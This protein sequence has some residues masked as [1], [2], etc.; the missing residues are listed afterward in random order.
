MPESFTVISVSYFCRM[1]I[2]PQSSLLSEEFSK[3]KELI[4]AHCLGKGGKELV[5][6][7]KP[8]SDLETIKSLLGK[9]EEFRKLLSA[10]ENFPSDNY[11][12]LLRELALLNIEN[13]VLQPEQVLNIL[14]VTK[15][16]GEIFNFF[17]LNSHRFPLLNLIIENIVFEKDR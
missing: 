4:A 14:L 10:S 11:K 6:D 17:S 8:W 13:S 9:T 15:T 3:I 2:F 5:F 7:L 16:T 1:F 12:D